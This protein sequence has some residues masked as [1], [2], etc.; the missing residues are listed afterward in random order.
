[1]S[2]SAIRKSLST[3]W[4]RR[5]TDMPK[6]GK[7]ASWPRTCL[8][9]VT[10]R[11]RHLRQVRKSQSGTTGTTHADPCKQRDAETSGNVFVAQVSGI[12]VEVLAQLVEVSSFFFA[13]LQCA[14]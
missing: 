9:E 10:D 8:D 1:I 5:S 6:G 7:A 13:T 14:V 4:A 11:D 2:A 3:V 12:P